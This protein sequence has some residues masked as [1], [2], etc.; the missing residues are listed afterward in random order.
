MTLP[1]SQWIAVYNSPINSTNG[2]YVFERCFCIEGRTRAV[3][4]LQVLADDI[5]DSILVC[6]RKMTNRTPNYTHNWFVT[7]PRIYRDTV[8]LQSGTCCIRVYVRNTQ[9]LPLVSI[10]RVVLLPYS[11]R[12]PFTSC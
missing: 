6:G 10:S 4:E 5:V 7:P 11:T 3:V 1:G 9:L 8:N 2:V 12:C